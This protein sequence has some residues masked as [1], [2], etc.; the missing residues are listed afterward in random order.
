[1]NQ[2]VMRWTVAGIGLLTAGYFF[3]LNAMRHG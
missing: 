2:R 3:L 1:V